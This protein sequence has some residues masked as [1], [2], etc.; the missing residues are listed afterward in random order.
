M[1]NLGFLIA[2]KSMLEMK[3]SFKKVRKITLDME[4][5]NEDTYNISKTEAILFSKAHN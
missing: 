4:A 3:E 5:R 1:D 2:D